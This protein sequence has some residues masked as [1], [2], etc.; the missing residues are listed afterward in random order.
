M[1]LTGYKKRNE[2]C[3]ISVRTGGEKFTGIKGD[4]AEKRS[5]GAEQSVW[6]HKKHIKTFKLKGLA[7]LPRKESSSVV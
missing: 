6:R 5:T 1:Q 2:E 4:Q 7:M 3:K